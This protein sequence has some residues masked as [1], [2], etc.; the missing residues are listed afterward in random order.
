MPAP[1]KAQKRRWPVLLFLL[2][3]LAYNLFRVALFAMTRTGAVTPD[4]PLDPTVDAVVAYSEL[5]IGIVGLAALPGL[6]GSRSWGFWATVVV[7]AYAV[8]FDA[9]SA[10]VVQLSAA[11]GVVPPV[12]ILLLLFVFRRRFASRKEDA[13]ARTPADA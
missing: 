7:N 11:G 3:V 6:A 2:F 5:V 4:H 1:P 12:I 9:L 10:V 13:P 8:G